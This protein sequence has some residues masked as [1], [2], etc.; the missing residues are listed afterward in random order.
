MPGWRNA[1]AYLIGVR[2]KPTDLTLYN[3]QSAY[4]LIQASNLS[5]EQKKAARHRFNVEMGKAKG[6]I[7]GPE[8]PAGT[9]SATGTYQAP[10]Y[11]PAS[12]YTTPTYSVP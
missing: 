8:G 7:S 9:P 1:V 5:K 4:N 6:T 3:L 2:V 12:G 10:T 11:T